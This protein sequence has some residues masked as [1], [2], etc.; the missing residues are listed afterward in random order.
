MA[1]ARLVLLV[2]DDPSLLDAM[3]KRLERGEFE[4]AI[5][6]D[7]RTAVK[8]LEGRVPDVACIDLGL[9]NESGYELC[10]HI[11]R[12]LSLSQVPLVVTSERGF[13]QDM[14][15]AEE[16]GANVFLRKP[17]GLDVLAETI[18]ELLLAGPR[19]RRDVRRLRSC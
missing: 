14:A 18:E 13:P 4:V 7:Y 10:E 16:A 15:Q 17:F 19:S 2:E 6:L 8:R 5:A 3:G 12:T 1:A 11:R 9:P